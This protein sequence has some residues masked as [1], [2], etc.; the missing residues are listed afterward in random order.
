MK[1]EVVEKYNIKN[2]SIDKY[3]PLSVG[4]GHFVFTCDVTGLQTLKEDYDVIP[5]L[6]MS[7]KFAYKKTKWSI[8]LC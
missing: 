6:S 8:T 5:L 7:E 3:C 4:N 1:K 2:E